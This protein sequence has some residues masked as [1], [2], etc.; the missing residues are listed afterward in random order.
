MRQLEYST[1]DAFP[2]CVCERERHPNNNDAQQDCKREE[3]S[4]RER[5]KVRERRT[6]YSSM[7]SVAESLQPHTPSRT[8]WPRPI[9]CFIFTG[10]FPQK[11]PM[12]SGSSMENDLRLN[13][14]YGSSPF[15]SKPHTPSALGTEQRATPRKAAP[16]TEEQG[17]FHRSPRA[18]GAFGTRDCERLISTHNNTGL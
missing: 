15:C 1:S 13:A 11:S 4:A 16:R 6:T 3:G 17:T 10:H 14:S 8:G 9:G 5:S 7:Q 12:I 18:D 2:P